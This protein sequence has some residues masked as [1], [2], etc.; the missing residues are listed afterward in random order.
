MENIII[1]I[2]YKLRLTILMLNIQLTVEMI[3]ELYDIFMK[4]GS[5]FC[6]LN[7]IKKKLGKLI[8]QNIN[9]NAKMKQL[10]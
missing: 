2:K 9:Q 10:F 8:P 3:C 4:L 1:H 6:L 5:M 7:I